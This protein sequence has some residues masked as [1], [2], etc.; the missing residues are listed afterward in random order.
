MRFRWLPSF[1]IA[2][3]RGDLRYQGVFDRTLHQDVVGAMGSRLAGVQQLTQ[4][5]R[6]AATSRSA[7]AA[8]MTGLCRPA[9]RVTW[10]QRRRRTGHD[11]AA[12]LGTAGKERMI[13][14]QREQ[15]W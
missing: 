3:R 7:S 9:S 11:L 10:G 14:A 12:D 1:K 4:A 13:E 5:M 8:M 2:Q 15:L 6:R